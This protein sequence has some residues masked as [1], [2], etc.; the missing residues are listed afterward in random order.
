MR[1]E[2]D[3][4]DRV[5]TTSNQ[6][7]CCPAKQ[8]RGPTRRRRDMGGDCSVEAERSPPHP[9]AGTPAEDMEPMPTGR[10][11]DPAARTGL[12]HEEA[13]I[14]QRA[15]W[16]GRAAERQRPCRLLSP[17]TSGHLGR[18]GDC[19]G[20]ASIH[21]RL[22]AHTED[23][24][25]WKHARARGVAAAAVDAQPDRVLP[26][27]PLRNSLQVVMHIGSAAPPRFPIRVSTAGV[28]VEFP[29]SPM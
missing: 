9:D 17:A 14:E 8:V 4:W 10:L 21:G 18:D 1:R 3:G 20:Q 11:A 28:V 7:T 13:R 16:G 23:G 5:P 29:F 15:A 22:T 2:V 27:P 26:P 25:I 12:S 6:G 19:E 24:S